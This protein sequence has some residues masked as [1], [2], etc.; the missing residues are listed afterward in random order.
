MKKKRDR[1]VGQLYRNY[2]ILWEIKYDDDFL[3]EPLGLALLKE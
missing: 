1:K 2:E 3:Q